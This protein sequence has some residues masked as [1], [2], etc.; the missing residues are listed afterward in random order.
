MFVE[1]LDVIDS[2]DCVSMSQ[3][4]CKQGLSHT[5]DKIAEYYSAIGKLIKT[6]T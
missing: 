5:V 6:K 4:V 1:L 2:E 3:L